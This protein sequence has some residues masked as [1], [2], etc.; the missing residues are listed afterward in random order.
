[1]FHETWEHDHGSS[2]GVVED[3]HL[4]VASHFEVS[5]CVFVAV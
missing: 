1:M 3:V 2:R 4:V 5:A